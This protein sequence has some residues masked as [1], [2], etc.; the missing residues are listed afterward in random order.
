MITQDYPTKADDHVML[1]LAHL[2]GKL[3]IACFQKRHITMPMSMM[4]ARP[5]KYVFKMAIVTTTV[6]YCVFVPYAKG[7]AYFKKFYE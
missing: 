2:L 1:A 6:Q 3:K 7:D 5:G 4:G